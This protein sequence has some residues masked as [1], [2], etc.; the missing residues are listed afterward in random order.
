MQ[1]I[2]TT[3]QALWSQL[4]DEL[5]AHPQQ[6]WEWGALKEKTG[7]WEAHRIVFKEGDETVGAAQVLLRSMP[8]PFRQIA[9]APRGPIARDQARLPE[10]ADAA[11]A[12]AKEH[13]KSVSLKI[14][15]AVTELA[16]SADWKPSERVLVSKTAVIDLTPSEDD[17]MKGIPN[18]KARQ[19][20]RKAGRDGV[21][22]RPGTKDDLP[23]ILAMY[24]ATAEADG[25]AIHEDHFYYEALETLGDVS[26]LFVAERDETLHAFLWNATT[27]GTAFELWGAVS[28]EGKRSRANY[29]L[30]W[31]AIC[32]AKERG[33]QLYDL[34]G[35]LNDGISDFK[36]LFVREPTI[37]VGSFDRPLSPLFGAMN[38]SLEMRRK[39]QSRHSTQQ[40]TSESR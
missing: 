36:L 38:A 9:Y 15:P 11:A 3:D 35:L 27:S 1:T 34:N 20:I 5:R 7:P 14:D 13:T 10:I 22:I 29:L 39:L 18:R 23:Q 28:D 37:W 12:W 31:V 8:F 2:E 17:L 32:A 26:Q 21:V 25:F 24:K 40:D 30:K 19:Y 16:L 33:A 6:S 4:V